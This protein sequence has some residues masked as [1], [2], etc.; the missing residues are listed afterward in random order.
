MKKNKN[1][2]LPE[3]LMTEEQKEIARQE[4]EESDAWDARFNYEFP[5]FAESSLIANDVSIMNDELV[6]IV[7]RVIWENE[8][9]SYYDKYRILLIDAS[10]FDTPKKSQYIDLLVDNN[11]IVIITNAASLDVY[12]NPIISYTL[13]ALNSMGYCIILQDKKDMLKDW[14]VEGYAG[15]IAKLFVDDIR[16][17]CDV[18]YLPIKEEPKRKEASE[19]ANADSAS[20][21]KNEEIKSPKYYGD[22][23][24]KIL[25][26]IKVDSAEEQ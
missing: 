12:G 22:Y 13:L 16:K 1:L 15:N 20:A 8:Q 19:K 4:K 25:E 21:C 10:Y 18:L 11:C 9:I 14:F 17:N 6:D 3:F 23:I 24:E 5:S 2:P 7:R 26:N